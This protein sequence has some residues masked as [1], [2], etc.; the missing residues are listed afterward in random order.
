[1][2]R[3]YKEVTISKQDNAFIIKLDGRA[4]KTPLKDILLIPTLKIAEII[5]AE[6]EAQK[7]EI[8]SFSMPYTKLAN[9]A[10][11]RVEKRRSALIDELCHYAGNDQIC[12]RAGFPSDLVR[13]QD[14]I[15]NPLLSWLLSQHD[16]TLHVTTGIVHIEQDKAEIAKI[17]SITEALESYRLTCFYGM[18]TVTGS[19]TIALNMIGGNI[20]LES[21][22]DAGHLDEN[23]QS[24]QW[25]KDDEAEMRKDELKK[26]LECSFTFYNLL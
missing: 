26:E 9:T 24:D 6:W 17:R 8:D 19:I 12:Y 25:G 23:Y 7:E 3:F 10:A 4:I 2:K 1:M 20:T 18:V 15:W 16:I 13:L 11:D 14:K 21:A 5:K 22:W